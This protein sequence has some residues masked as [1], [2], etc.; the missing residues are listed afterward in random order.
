M[1]V[2]YCAYK[3]AAFSLDKHVQPGTSASDYL[4]A[5]LSV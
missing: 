5:K 2:K 4:S 3:L 1:Q